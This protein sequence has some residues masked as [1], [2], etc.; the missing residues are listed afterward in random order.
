[1]SRCNW[2]IGRIGVVGVASVLSL[3]VSG[4]DWSSD[5][6]SLDFALYASADRLR[7][8]TSTG[9]G[10]RESQASSEIS[11]LRTFLS[12]REDGWCKPWYGVPVGRVRA[13][14]YAGRRFLGSVHLGANFVG[15]G[16]WR[17]RPA[18]PEER[19]EL[20][21]IFAVEDPYAQSELVR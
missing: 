13:E 12:E 8:A 2:R 21:S 4:C 10:L 7:I 15:V 3:A 6:R 14:L 1:M 17:V 11:A 20:L 9:Q 18:G 5:C 19:Q 16:M